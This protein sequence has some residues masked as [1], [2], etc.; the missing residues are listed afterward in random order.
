MFSGRTLLPRE[1]ALFLMLLDNLNHIL[2][3]QNYSINNRF[4]N[5]EDSSVWNCQ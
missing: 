2:D 5:P 3:A 4:G 1:P